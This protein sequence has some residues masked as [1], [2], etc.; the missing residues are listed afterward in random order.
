MPDETQLPIDTNPSPVTTLATP[1]NPVPKKPNKLTWIILLIVLILSIGVGSYLL[2]ANWANEK[3]DTTNNSATPSPHVAETTLKKLTLPTDD[4]KAIVKKDTINWLKPTATASLNLQSCPKDGPENSNTGLDCSEQDFKVGEV[5]D[6]KYAGGEVLIAKVRLINGKYPQVE[7]FRFIKTKAS[8]VLLGLYS[9][10]VDYFDFDKTKYTIDS[11]YEIPELDLPDYL[12]GSKPNQVLK[13][14]DKNSITNFFDISMV[15]KVFTDKIVGDVY[16]SKDETVYNRSGEILLP[17]GFDVEAKAEKLRLDGFY[18]P[19]P[20]GTFEVY[21]IYPAFVD[22]LKNIEGESVFIPQIKW[23]NGK[24]NDSSYRFD[25]I[26]GCETSNNDKASAHWY[27]QVEREKKLTDLQEVGKTSTGEN[28]YS[29]K[30]DADWKP[31]V[32]ILNLNTN[33]DE[34]VEAFKSS[35][36]VFFWVDP[37]NRLIRFENTSYFYLIQCDFY[38]I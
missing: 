29:F 34:S 2:L 6:G 22:D 25:K 9:E 32:E 1:I 35:F 23:N 11:T 13:K 37:F 24:I 21:T 14:A 18:V 36:P 28:I 7:Y 12:F 30:S 8:L 4:R 38:L 19:K 27:A 10:K 15:K 26:S 3:Q 5:K 16:T 31:L 17:K 20:D 33:G